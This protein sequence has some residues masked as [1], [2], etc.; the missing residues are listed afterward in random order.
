[1]NIFFLMPKANDDMERL[2]D[3]LQRKHPG[4]TIEHLRSVKKLSQRLHQLSDKPDLILLA[5]PEIDMLRKVLPLTRLLHPHRVVIILPDREQETLHLAH[6]LR[7]RY[8]TDFDSEWHQLA[9][10]LSRMIDIYSRPGRQ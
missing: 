8:V 2:R 3:T 4:H 6:R 5:F 1:M 9:A 10:V 7:P